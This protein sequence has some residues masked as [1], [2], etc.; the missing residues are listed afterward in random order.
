MQLKLNFDKVSNEKIIAEIKRYRLQV[1][2]HSCIYYR[3][4][5]SIISDAEFDKRACRL[6]ELQKKY[7]EESK[8]VAFYEEFKDFDGYTGYHLPYSYP[9]IVAKAVYLLGGCLR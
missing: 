9:G 4:N 5:T 1:L 6:A 2:I 3:F 8:E 7:P